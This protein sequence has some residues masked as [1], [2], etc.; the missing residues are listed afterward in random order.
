GSILVVDHAD[1]G[2][3]IILQRSERV[4]DDANTVAARSQVVVDAAPPGP[5]YEGAV[6]Q[7]NVIHGLVGG[8]GRQGLGLRGAGEHSS[9]STCGDKFAEVSNHE[10]SPLTRAR[11]NRVRSTY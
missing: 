5:V 11:F 3:H 8:N 9:R 7:H 10:R 1:R 4:L 6:N 2:G